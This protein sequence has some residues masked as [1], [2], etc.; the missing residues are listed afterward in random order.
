MVT[1]RKD[2]MI[3]H[4]DPKKKYYLATMRI[5]NAPG[6]LGNVANLLAVRG[7][8][9]LE[10]YFGGI[11]HD[12]HGVVSFFVESVNPKLDSHWLKE[13]IESSVSVSDV[14]VREG[15][16][17]FLFDSLNFPLTWNTG[18]RAIL[19]RTEG[20]RAMLNAATEANPE[21]GRQSLYAQG[22]FYGKTSWENLMTI[23]RPRTKEGLSE[24]LQVYS[25]AGW[26]RPELVHLDIGKMQALVRLRDGFE[27]PDQRTGACECHFTRGHLAGSFSSFFGADVNCTETKCLSKNGDYCE[28]ELKP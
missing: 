26:G 2:V 15:T 27:C 18:E 12:N 17:G 10:G 7:I 3:Y 28:F 20:A 14:A 1:R 4:Y 11:S 13:F 5:E 23:H 6:I 25:A 22:F 21:S 9:I 24:V 16:E 19:M 8:N